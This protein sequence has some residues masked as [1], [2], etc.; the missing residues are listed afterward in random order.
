MTE[1]EKEIL[2]TVLKDIK[3]KATFRDLSQGFKEVTGQRL[4]C[5]NFGF[6]TNSEFLDSIPDVSAEIM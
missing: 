6:N 5:G 3:V 1:L 2:R 4:N